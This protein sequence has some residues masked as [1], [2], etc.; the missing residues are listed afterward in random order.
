MLLEIL[1]QLTKTIQI[2]LNVYDYWFIGIA[3]P[4]ASVLFCLVLFETESHSITDTYLE[5]RHQPHECWDS[6]SAS[7]S[8]K[9]HSIF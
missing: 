5:M 8:D 7:L 1:E 3:T 6:R 4:L 9:L 2:T